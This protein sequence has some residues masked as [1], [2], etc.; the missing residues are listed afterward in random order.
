MIY[1]FKVTATTKIKIGEK[2]AAFE[3][4]SALTDKRASIT[5]VPMREGNVAKKVEIEQ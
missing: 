3:D 1:N 2:E 4:L 5:F